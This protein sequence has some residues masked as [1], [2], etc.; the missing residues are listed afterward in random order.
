MGSYFKGLLIFKI[1]NLNLKFIFLDTVVLK[2][3]N[4]S[5]IESVTS[6]FNFLSSNV[7]FND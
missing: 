3:N 7:I 4:S 6:T 1:K 5:S 2:K